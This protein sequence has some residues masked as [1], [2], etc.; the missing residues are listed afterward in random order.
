MCKWWEREKMEERN[1]SKEPSKVHNSLVIHYEY[2][3]IISY[4]KESIIMV[5]LYNTEWN[6]V[7]YGKQGTPQTL[8]QVESKKLCMK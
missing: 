5:I 4:S 6:K 2:I 1:S 7:R 8:H 3:I